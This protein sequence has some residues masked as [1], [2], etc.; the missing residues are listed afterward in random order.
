M[1][2]DLGTTLDMM[3]EQDA[4]MTLDMARERDLSELSD[5]PADELDASSIQDADLD[6]DLAS[7]GGIIEAPDRVEVVVLDLAEMAWLPEPQAPLDCPDISPAQATGLSLA[8]AVQGNEQGDVLVADKD[9]YIEYFNLRGGGV[10]SPGTIVGSE[11]YGRVVPLPRDPADALIFFNGSGSRTTISADGGFELT[12]FQPTPG[13]ADDVLAM[14]PDAQTYYSVPYPYQGDAEP[15][16]LK[17]CVVSAGCQEI[18]IVSERA[19][20]HMATFTSQDGHVVWAGLQ[21]IWRTHLVTGE[22]VMLVRDANPRGLTAHGQWLA[23]ITAQGTLRVTEMGGSTH[24][25][26]D[27]ALAVPDEGPAERRIY[28]PVFLALAM[29]DDRVYWTSEFRTKAFDLQKR[30]P[31]HTRLESHHAAWIVASRCGY[32][33]GKVEDEVLQRH[34]VLGIPK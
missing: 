33:L 3:R 13:Y 28:A 10:V 26:I 19:Q 11:V 22:S 12:S 27:R 34:E 5:M 2:N 21:H 17:K 14:W 23:W 24:W 16:A 18:G 8:V 1:R 29:D 20:Y 32:T 4:G 15:M 30:Q 7:D 9:D 25:E 31:V 6:S